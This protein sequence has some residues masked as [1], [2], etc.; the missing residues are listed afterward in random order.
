LENG[1]ESESC[2]HHFKHSSVPRTDAAG[3][4]DCLKQ[5]RGKTNYEAE[6]TS[7]EVWG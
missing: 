4:C 2:A 6:N 5:H 3:R 1:T 7:I